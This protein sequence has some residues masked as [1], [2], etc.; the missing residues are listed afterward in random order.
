MTAALCPS[1]LSIQ[2]DQQSARAACVLCGEP[3]E[4]PQGELGFHSQCMEE[5]LH[6]GKEQ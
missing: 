4:I 3:T 2:A 6:H 5:V 1:C